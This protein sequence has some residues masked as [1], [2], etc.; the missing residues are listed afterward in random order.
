MIVR[1]KNGRFAKKMDNKLGLTHPDKPEVV[2]DTHDK[3]VYIQYA[4][5]PGTNGFLF[6]D[7][8]SPYN[9]GVDPNPAVI[10]LPT[11]AAAKKWHKANGWDCDQIVKVR[12][13][14]EKID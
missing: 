3:K 6:N 11:L 14:V 4:F 10:L 2:E 7:H 8:D 9:Y 13:T 1:E 12:V 5:R